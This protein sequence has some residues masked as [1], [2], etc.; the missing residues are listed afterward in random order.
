[1]LSW[2]TTSETNSDHFDVE[3]SID[4]K[5]WNK[6]GVVAANFNSESIK[7]YAFVDKNPGAKLAYYRLKMV[8]ADQ[9]FAYSRLESVR[10]SQDPQTVV[11]PNP[12]DSGEP[13]NLLNN[14]QVYKIQVYDLSGKLRYES[15]NIQGGIKVQDLPTGRYII[16]ITMKDG[17]ENS[18]VFVKK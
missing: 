7:N 16:K 8:D 4:A 12:A 6:I 10:F 14:D 5:N 2:K 11:Y 13:I 15:E 17:S 3:K 1:M 18:H 9:T